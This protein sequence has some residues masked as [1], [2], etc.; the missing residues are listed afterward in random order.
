MPTSSPSLPYLVARLQAAVLR[1]AG[2]AARRGAAL[3]VS[4]PLDFIFSSSRQINSPA[5]RGGTVGRLGWGG[6]N[7][8]LPLFSSLLR[9]R[10]FSPPACLAKAPLFIM[11]SGDLRVA[12]R[13]GQRIGEVP[14]P[15]P[16]SP[17]PRR[18]NRADPGSQ[19]AARVPILVVRSVHIINAQPSSDLHS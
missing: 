4:D 12:A 7:A 14:L 6:K 8:R 13:L 3:S 2:S 5:D 15:S 9:D 18:V 1:G 19:C 10:S 16:S 11:R 17:R